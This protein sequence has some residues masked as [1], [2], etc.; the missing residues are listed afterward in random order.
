MY[1]ATIAI[2]SIS[3][4]VPLSERRRIRQFLSLLKPSRSF[5]GMFSTRNNFLFN[6]TRNYSGSTG[7]SLVFREY[8]A[9]TWHQCSRTDIVDF[10][11]IAEIW[12]T[13]CSTFPIY[14][15]IENVEHWPHGRFIVFLTSTWTWKDCDLSV[16]SINQEWFLALARSTTSRGCTCSQCRT[17]Y[18]IS[19]QQKWGLCQ[20]SLR[21]QTSTLCL[22]LSRV[23]PR[24]SIAPLFN[25]LSLPLS[26]KNYLL[27]GL[28]CEPFV[29]WNFDL[30]TAGN[31][32]WGRK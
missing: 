23:A 31:E 10:L 15:I 5:M 28:Q 8:Q 16:R 13:Q 12:S 19:T 2:K 22:A 21:A 9:E 27:L 30:L 25:V 24:R 20:V 18:V 6:Y 3:R 26:A 14:L 1:R 29:S 4:T 32:I 11:D 17:D 7:I